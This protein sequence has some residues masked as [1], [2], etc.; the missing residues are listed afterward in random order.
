MKRYVI[1]FKDGWS[2]SFVEGTPQ[3]AIK[4]VADNYN[5]NDCSRLE[6]VPKRDKGITIKWY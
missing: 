2:A 1:H 4:Y 6:Y 3:E 5:I